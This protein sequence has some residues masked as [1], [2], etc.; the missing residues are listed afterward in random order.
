[1]DLY[2]NYG[3]AQKATQGVILWWSII[4]SPGCDEWCV[5]LY[6]IR[7]RWPQLLYFLSFMALKTA[8]EWKQ[9]GEKPSPLSL[10]AVGYLPLNWEE[11][12]W[13]EGIGEKRKGEERR[14]KGKTRRVEKRWW[15][16]W[17]GKIIGEERP[18]YTNAVY[19]NWTLPQATLAQ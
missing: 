4:S 12:S 14:G 16:E 11:K 15:E 5:L 17:R 10:C 13:K 2:H 8:T 7:N 1:M 6:S 18:A 3:V 9:T 19:S